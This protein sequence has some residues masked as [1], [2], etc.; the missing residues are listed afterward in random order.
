ME[1]PANHL[2]Y[3]FIPG[4]EITEM[5]LFM[6]FLLYT[7]LSLKG[8]CPVFFCLPNSQMTFIS[9]LSRA[10]IIFFHAGSPAYMLLLLPG[11]ILL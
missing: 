1:H 9:C 3:M 4:K 10:F 7:L 5:V 6:I 8:K 11:K 2:M